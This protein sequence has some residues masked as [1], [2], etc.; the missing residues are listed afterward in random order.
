MGS[1]I[2]AKNPEGR[3][4]VMLAGHADEIGFIVRYISDDGCLYF[5]QIGGHD[6]IFFGALGGPPKMPDHISLW[7]RCCC[8]AGSSI[9]M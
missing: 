7:A 3:P 5:G 6:A 8:F 1:V 9:S 2:A 4:R